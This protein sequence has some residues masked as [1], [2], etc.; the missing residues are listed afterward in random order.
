MVKTKS[1][2]TIVE[3]LIVIVVIGII[4]TIA[5][6]AYNGIQARAN[7]AATVSAATAWIKAFKAYEVDNGELPHTGYDS[8]L[9]TGYPWDLDSLTS[10]TNQ[11]RYASFSYYVEKPTIHNALKP[12][13][14]SQLP[15]P[16]MQTIGTS[17]TWARGIIY[18]APS[19]GGQFQLTVVLANL[20][21]CPQINGLSGSLNAITNG[22]LCNYPLG[23]RLR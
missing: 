17:T 4:A 6:V 14:N 16:S 15:S 21:S 22:I 7:N 9:G 11:C 23:I 20:S 1:G 10:G 13:M 8:C 18:A 2:F 12:Y 19:V 5:I 3:L